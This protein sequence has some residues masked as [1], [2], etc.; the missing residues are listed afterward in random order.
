MLLG[1]ARLL[2]A[3]EADLP[4]VVKLIF[5]PAEE[6]GAGADRMCDEGVLR[7]PDVD[8]IFG[9]HVWP[10]ATT[11]TVMGNAGV[12][13]AAVGS[14]EIVVTG[15]SG[16]G[17]IPHTAIDPVACAATIVVALQTIVSRESNPFAPTVV[18]VASIH[19]GDAMNVIPDTVRMTGTFRSLSLDELLRVKQRIEDICRH[20]AAANRCEVAF[21]YPVR[22]HPA[23]TNDDAAWAIARRA[24]EELVGAQSVGR[25]E[26]VLGGEDFA[27]YQQRVPGCFTFIGVSGA[28]W[29][30]RYGVHH[31]KFKVDEAA[32][33]IGAALHVATAL[34]ALAPTR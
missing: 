15:K 28:E 1:A 22:E 33:P 10:G 13:L 4:G 2:K 7:A 24:A 3:R 29:P 30:A 17:A 12:I 34:E 23:T 18:T 19:G 20:V 8:Q 9:L 21:S 25:M 32:L 26:P 5:Q 27:F 6:G 16:H 31:E 14:F 11:G